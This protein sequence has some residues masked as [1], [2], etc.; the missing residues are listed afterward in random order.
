MR[1]KLSTKNPLKG[2]IN[3]AVRAYP[4]STIPIW[5]LLA[6]NSSLRYRGSRGVRIMK[7]KYIMK[8]AL[9]AFR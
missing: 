2:L 8:L 9:H 4:L 6:P 1:G 5:S 3:N 7:E